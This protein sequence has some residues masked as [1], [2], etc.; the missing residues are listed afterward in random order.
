VD[1]SPWPR[2]AYHR[3]IKKDSGVEA[4]NFKIPSTFEIS[5]N[6]NK[7]SPEEIRGL[8]IFQTFKLINNY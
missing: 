4:I 8:A 7:T 6:P 2:S 3:R 5:Y 1:N